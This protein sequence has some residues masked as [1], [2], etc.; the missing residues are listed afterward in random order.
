MTTRSEDAVANTD[1]ELWREQPGDYYANSI[2]VTKGGGIGINVGGTV[3][4]KPLAEWHRLA[5]PQP[6][7]SDVRGLTK[8]ERLVLEWLAKED[9]SA[10]GEC[11]GA[12]LDGL[13][14]KGFAILH[15][16]RLG[17][18]KEYDR[19]TVTESGRAT[20]ARLSPPSS[21]VSGYAAEVEK[22][23]R[24][25]DAEIGLA[26]P[27]SPVSGE[28]DATIL[29]DALMKI[30]GLASDGMHHSL[31]AIARDAIKAFDG[32]VIAT[33]PP[34]QS[35]AS[36]TPVAW[37]WRFHNYVTWH[38]SDEKNA[39]NGHRERDAIVEPLYTHPPEGNARG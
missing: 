9:S 37:R 38:F 3:I 19:V 29:R 26:P 28:G 30:E 7:P 8:D 15:R 34:P 25:T 36:G 6:S 17:R 20:L 14:E 16:D 32:S 18:G 21:P 33:S 11:H 4:V 39:A 5:A 35:A 10:Y 27:V 2:H 31:R 24:A 12:A 1:V 22:V 23:N 13:V